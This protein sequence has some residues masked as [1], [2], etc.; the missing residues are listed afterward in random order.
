MGTHP[1]AWPENILS[2]LL[3][4]I[5]VLIPSLDIHSASINPAGPAPT[6]RTSTSDCGGCDMVGA[7]GMNYQTRGRN[8]RKDRAARRPEARS[9]RIGDENSAAAGY[10]TVE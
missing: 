4:T 9:R 5:R 10:G 2:V 3:S 7:A 6:I 8:R 1:S